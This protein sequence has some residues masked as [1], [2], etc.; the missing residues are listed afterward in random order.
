MHGTDS[1]TVAPVRS[2]GQ[3][4]PSSGELATE[5]SLLPPQANLTPLDLNHSVSATWPEVR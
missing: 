2:Y 3:H 5:P 1:C 4:M